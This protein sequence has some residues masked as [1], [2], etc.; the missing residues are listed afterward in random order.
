MEISANLNVLVT[1]CN[2]EHEQ[3]VIQKRTSKAEKKQKRWEYNM[4]KKQQRVKEKEEELK[5]CREESKHTLWKC[6][7]VCV[8]V[9]T[10]AGEGHI[11]CVGLREAATVLRENLRIARL[12]KKQ[13]KRNSVMK[14]LTET[15][16][17]I[18]LD[19]SFEHLMNTKE[20]HSLVTQIQT[21]YGICKHNEIPFHLYLT[22]LQ[23]ESP[24]FI[25]LAQSKGFNHWL[26]VRTTEQSVDAYF[27]SRVSDLVYLSPDSSELLPSVEEHKIYIIGGLVDNSRK[28]HISKSKALDL[29]IKC[30]CLPIQNYLDCSNRDNVL[31]ISDVGQILGLFL[32]HK[33]WLTVF[34]QFS[35]MNSH[36]YPRLIGET[37][38]TSKPLS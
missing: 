19:L 4:H 20:M 11:D 37:D 26:G 8:C 33:D 32:V 36:R 23:Q 5:R 7:C 16:Y 35:Q 18:A 21:L 24:T 3:V 10:I 13:Q 12:E 9:T 2:R 22:N 38:N 29:Q 1:E 14:K 34:K 31:N 17:A 28:K 25:Q 27:A 6:Y 30:Y 15:D